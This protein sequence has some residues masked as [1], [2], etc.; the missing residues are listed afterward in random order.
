MLAAK[1]KQ[2]RRDRNMET[3]EGI[4][5]TISV[6]EADGREFLEELNKSNAFWTSYL[7]GRWRIF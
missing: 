5:K 1:R 4:I 6:K 7:K 3:F 2:C